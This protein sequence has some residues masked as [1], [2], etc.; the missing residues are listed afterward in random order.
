MESKFSAKAKIL[1]KFSE[2]VHPKLKF[3]IWSHRM[4][5]HA[6]EPYVKNAE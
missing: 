6:K 2:V 3:G 4:P 5:N 1:W